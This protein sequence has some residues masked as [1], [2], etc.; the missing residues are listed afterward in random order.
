MFLGITGL[1]VAGQILIVTFGGE[2]FHVTP[3]NWFDWLTIAV[4][5]MSVLVFG[6]ITRQV[7]R[8][9]ER[10]PQISAR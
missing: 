10:K 6:E 9:I 8:L 3:L 7:R 1:I 4:A 5:T 2:V